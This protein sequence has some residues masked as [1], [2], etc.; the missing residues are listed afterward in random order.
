MSQPGE[1]VDVR[2]SGFVVNGGAEFRL[3]P[4]V[5][6]GVRCPGQSG[7]GDHRQRRRLAAGG[8]VRSRWDRGPVQ[9]RH[10][11]LTRACHA[12]AVK[13]DGGPATPKRRSRDGG[14]PRQSGKARRRACHAKAA[15]AA[16][17]LPRQSGEAAT[18]GV[19]LMQMTGRRSGRVSR[20]LALVGMAIYAI[21]LIASPFEHHDLSCELKTPQHCTSCTSTQ[22]GSDTHVLLRPARRSWRM[23]AAPM[24]SSS[25]IKERCSSSAPPAA[26]LPPTSDS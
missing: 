1:D 13:R 2:H 4:W 12:K 20:R 11:P 18:A 5:G 24:R 23:P 22:L 26:P 3:H 25:S 7:E 19:Y 14:V 9:A 6:L 10:R 16:A 15:N 8:G 17:G 21:F